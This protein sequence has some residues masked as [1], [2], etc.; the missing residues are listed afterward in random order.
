MLKKLGYR[1]QQQVH[2]M[3]Q[4]VFNIWHW[5]T[6]RWHIVAKSCPDSKSFSGW[7]AISGFCFAPLGGKQEKQHSSSTASLWSLLNLIRHDVSQPHSLNY[8]HATMLLSSIPGA[9][10]VVVV[11]IPI[12]LHVKFKWYGRC[13]VK[14]PAVPYNRDQTKTGGWVWITRCDAACFSAV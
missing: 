6:T 11:L 7:M 8:P 12:C 14:V 13:A 4:T 9:F 2:R 10:V 5:N 3:I 1:N